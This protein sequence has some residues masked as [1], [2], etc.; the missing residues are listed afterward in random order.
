MI[1][2][3]VSVRSAAEVEAAL[4]GGADLIDVKD[5]SAGS[6]GMATGKVWREVSKAADE[7]V[8]L[9]A[10]L[11]EL[12]EFSPKTSVAPLEEYQFAK[13][14]L[15]GC[16]QNSKWKALFKQHL[17]SLPKSI[18]RTAMAY[19]DV[20]TANSPEPSEVLKAA[21]ALR[22]RVFMLDT[23]EKKEK[24]VFDLL[25]GRQVKK[26]F[27]EASEAGMITVLSG[28]LKLSRISEILEIM[29]D[30]V[31]VRGGVCPGLRTGD[32]SADL[33]ALWKLRLNKR[34]RGPKAHE[35]FS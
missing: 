15:S 1:Q 14:G 23:F 25:P 20:G 22:C 31:A 8:P 19:A 5:P 4:K 29:P 26:L 34:Q 7:Q 33:V 18:T 6:M 32:I 24:D 13:F 28:S 16:A 10:A 11:G 9:S 21:I 30:I 3:L 12:L 17:A 27:E 35:L 2:L